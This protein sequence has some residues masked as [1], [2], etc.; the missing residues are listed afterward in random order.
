[1]K[2]PR[3]KKLEQ[4]STPVFQRG[5]TLVELMVVISIVAVLATISFTLFQSTQASARDAKRRMDIDAVANSL[6][7]HYDPATG[8]YPVSLDA[9]WFSNKTIPEDPLNTSGYIYSTNIPIGGSSFVACAKLE[10]NGG[11]FSD[12]GTTPSSNGVYYCK[13]NQQQ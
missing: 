1:M 10:R 6:E 11:N 3:L 13:S 8:T 7:I 5:F 9:S 12:Q 4:N 2:E